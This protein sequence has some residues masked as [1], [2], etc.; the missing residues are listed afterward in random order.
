MLTKKSGSG[1]LKIVDLGVSAELE[2]V[3]TKAL[4]GTPHYMAPGAVG[5][6]WAWHGS[7][8]WGGRCGAVGLRGGRGG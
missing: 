2:R 7:V 4:A 1:L 8:A 5:G 3:F 6:R